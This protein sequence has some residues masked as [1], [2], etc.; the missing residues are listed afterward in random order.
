MRMGAHASP[1]W[2]HFR[3]CVW[4]H[5]HTHAYGRTCGWAH[6]SSRMG[7]H[8][9][10]RTRGLLGN[11]GMGAHANLQVGALSDGRTCVSPRAEKDSVTVTLRPRQGDALFRHC[12]VMQVGALARPQKNLRPRLDAILRGV[13]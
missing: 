9:D 12:D 1:G 13:L 11:F 3:T 5:I 6:I 2:A 8:T 10:G 7:A 4:A